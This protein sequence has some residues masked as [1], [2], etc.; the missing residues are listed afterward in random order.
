LIKFLNLD[1]LRNI[2]SRTVSDKHIFAKQ[3]FD[4]EARLRADLNSGLEKG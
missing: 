4:P 3:F 2:E 1:K